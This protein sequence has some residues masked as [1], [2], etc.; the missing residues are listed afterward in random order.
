MKED[1]RARQ[2]EV[3]EAL[4]PAY[5]PPRIHVVKPGMPGLLECVDR[6]RKLE[7]G[8]LE[9]GIGDKPSAAGLDWLMEALERH[10]RT[11][12]A[13]PLA[14]PTPEGEVS[15]EWEIAPHSASL[16][17]DLDKRHGYWHNLNM[18]TDQDEEGNLDLSSGRG[19]AELLRLVKGLDGNV[20]AVQ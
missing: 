2:D 19:W 9:D 12:C 16:E 8:W 13:L 6:M 10:Y 18:E 17:V 15:L 3:R 11:D 7:P 4:A 14:F 20:D 1:Q 5:A